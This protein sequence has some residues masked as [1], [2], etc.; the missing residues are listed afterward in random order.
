MKRKQKLMLIAT[1]LLISLVTSSCG[2]LKKTSSNGNGKI[3]EYKALE[4][5]DED[6]FYLAI[7]GDP[8]PETEENY[9]LVKDCGFR[10][11]FLDAWHGTGRGTETEKYVLETC[12]KLG[13]NVMIMP[14]NTMNESEDQLKHFEDLY[15]EDYTKYPAFKGTYAFDEPRTSQLDWIA[16]DLEMWENSKYKDYMYLVNLMAGD[17]DGKPTEEFLENYWKKVLSK[18]DDN[19]LMLDIYPL[20]ENADG[21]YLTSLG[22]NTLKNMDIFSNFAREKNSRFLTYLQTWDSTSRGGS[23]KLVSVNDLRFQCAYNLAYG[24]DGFACFTYYRFAQYDSAMTDFGGKPTDYYYYVQEVFEE[25]K[26]WEHVYFAFD[27][28]GTMFVEGPRRGYGAQDVEQFEELKYNLKEHDRIK[29]IET[30]YDLLVGTFKDKDDNDGFLFTSWTDPY[31]M[32]NNEVK[33]SF[34]ETTKALIYHNGKLITNDEKN[35]CYML[36]DGVLD[37]TLEAGDYLYV[38]PVK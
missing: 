37:Y 15:K 8:S 36:E 10:T 4:N 16:G 12:E 31:Y 30:E 34:N 7:F 2:M 33:I 28:E 5:P 27:Y 17:P 20:A 18:N 11:V 1:L 24:S 9:Q 6:G 21:K 26:E 35:S 19:I 22:R 38:I 13:L 23:R 25:L 14:N 29:E 3:P 32:K